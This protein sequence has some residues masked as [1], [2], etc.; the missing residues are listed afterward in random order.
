MASF[1]SL[2]IAFL[3]V[4]VGYFLFVP[5]S[6][7]TWL[8]FRVGK[9]KRASTTSVALGISLTARYDLVSVRYQDASYEDIGRIEESQ[10][11]LDMM[12]QFSL[13]S[14]SHPAYVFLRTT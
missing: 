11:Y 6:R 12:R 10:N 1:R 13:P 14:S 8:C 2:P 4:A 7:P 3:C 5:P 9:D